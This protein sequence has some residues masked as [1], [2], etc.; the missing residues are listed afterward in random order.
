[1]PTG[2]WDG[3]KIQFARPS[4]LFPPTA[5]STREDRMGGLT[6]QAPKAPGDVQSRP[7]DQRVLRFYHPETGPRQHPNT[8]WVGGGERTEGFLAYVSYRH[9]EIVRFWSYLGG[10][11]PLLATRQLPSFLLSPQPPWEQW[12]CS[13]CAPPAGT[14]EQ[15]IIDVLTKRSNAQRQQIAKSFKAQFGKVRVGQE[16]S[17]LG[18]GVGGHCCGRRQPGGGSSV[19]GEALVSRTMGRIGHAYTEN[20]INCLSEVRIPLAILRFI[21]QDKPR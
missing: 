20:I 5:I 8:V 15:A 9:H 2:C 18:V 6:V 3:T 10:V 16:S 1:M 11:C 14:N 13:H 12:G 7:D 19:L 4:V 21:G 17:F